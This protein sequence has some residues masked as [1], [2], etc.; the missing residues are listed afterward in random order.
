MEAAY[1][2]EVSLKLLPYVLHPRRYLL[3]NVLQLHLTYAQFSDVEIKDTSALHS[4][5]VFISITRFKQ[6]RLKKKGHLP[7]EIEGILLIVLM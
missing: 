4:L 1:P 7:S 6:K 5:S 3:L 2:S